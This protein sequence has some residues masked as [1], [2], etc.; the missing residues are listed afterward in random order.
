[1]PRVI[2]H[3][4]RLHGLLD[5]GI[6]L[7][8][9]LSLDAVLQKLVETA[10]GLTGARYAALG[11]IDRAG[12]ELERF[13]TTGIEPEVRA[14][15]GEL[16]RGRGILGVL[17]RETKPLRLH[18]LGEDPRS[19]GFPP[20]HPPMHTF[21]GVPIVLRG[22]AYGNL[23]L[24]ERGDGTDFTD[25]DEELVTLL[26]AQAAVA[27]ENARLYEA[28]TRWSR[29]LES[30]A[31]VGNALTGEV[32][33]SSLLELVAKRLRELIDARLV[34]VALAN[35]EAGLRVHTADGEH[36]EE[37]IGLVLDQN[38]SRTGR[39]F[40]RR[41]S[42]RTDSV[43]DDPEANQEI[44]RRLAAVTGLYVPLVVRDRSIGVIVAFNKIGPDPRFGEDDQR[45][46]EAFA[47]RAAV[48]VDLSERVARD[49][50]RRVFEAQE[51]ERRR[52]ALELHDE[53]GQALTSVLLGLR[54]VEEAKSEEELRQSVAELRELV[55][56]TLQD[57]R[58]LAVELRPSVLDDFGLTPALERL[59]R[60]FSEQTGIEVD[61]ESR[62]PDGRLPSE[63]ETALYRIVQESLTN[64]VKHARAG[65]VSILLTRKN[66]SVTAVIEDDGRGFETG[67]RSEGLGLVGMRERIALLGGRMEIETTPGS[68]TALVVEVPLL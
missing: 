31:E 29:Q 42:E 62:L 55:V 53:T 25:E 68:G 51:L 16:P 28:A 4:E 8:S 34:L 17:I 19:V 23:Y 63:V 18:S 7:S 44:A 48:A 1:M 66:G 6:S 27:I 54:S 22:A 35:A 20:G 11:V 64:V 15:I 30:L 38:G 40:E 3:E 21:L 56:G 14:E 57:V 5:A 46:A 52:I 47:A 12:R 59:V 65:R 43:I 26:A 58:R 49:S 13:L 50:L 2:G 32:E 61:F 9:E 10:A 45:L 37:A 36:A 33:L 24:C 41:Q 67:A 39:V 60:G